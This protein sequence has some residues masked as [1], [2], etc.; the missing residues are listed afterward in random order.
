MAE[1]EPKSVADD[2]GAQQT[3]RE[4]HDRRVPDELVKRLHE[5]NGRMDELRKQ[6][7]STLGAAEQGTGPRAAKV[8]EAMRAAE[9]EIEDLSRQ[10]REA[11]P[12]Q[13]KGQS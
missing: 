10:I 6:L 12:P 7:E 13:A 11:S 2:A 8:G 9:R 1:A 3:L 4:A 5:A